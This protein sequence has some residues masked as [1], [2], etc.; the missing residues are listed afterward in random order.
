M[1]LAGKIEHLRRGRSNTELAVAC[2]CSPANIQKIAREGSQP[3]FAL[4]VRL[5]AV[6]GVP[7]DWLGDDDADWPP[8]T[9]DR[10]RAA[11]LVEQALTG[12]GLAGELS[13][14]ERELLSSWRSLPRDVRNRTLGYV[15]GLAAGGTETA[16]ELGADVMEALDRADCDD[17]ERP[18]EPASRKGA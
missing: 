17:E 8:P 4:G 5:A 12:A 9:T 18:E 15:I 16:A 10:E 3:N 6:L 11:S 7:A 13:R 2:G 1:D 14:D